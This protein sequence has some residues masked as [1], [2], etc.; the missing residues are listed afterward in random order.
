MTA[1]LETA[2]KRADFISTRVFASITYL[3]Q[4]NF[5]GLDLDFEYPGSRGSPAADKHRF[6][7]L[8][9][10]L[11]QAFDAESQSTGNPALL[12]SV[13]V[14][15]GKPRVDNGYEVGQIAQV[16]DWI[17]LMSYDLH[18][19]WE[20]TT[21]HNSPLYHRSAEST[22]QR[23]L[24]VE[25]AANYWVQKGCPASKLVI[26]MP[27][28]GRG[29]TLANPA[30]H[31]M[32]AAA[33]G[34]GAAGPITATAGFIAYYE[35]CSE[36]LLA[37]G[38]RVFHAEH[39]VPYAFKNDQWVGYDDVQSLT[40]KVNWLQTQGYGG[41]MVWAL[42]LDDFKH[43]VCGQATPFTCTSRPDGFYA[44]PADCS[45]FY[46]CVWGH[47]FSFDCPPGIYWDPSISNCNW[48][49]NI[50]LAVLSQC[51]LL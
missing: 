30:N 16:V 13:A 38:T 47:P 27:T 35:V 21:G 10:E 1:M 14:P 31:G 4:R 50:P 41:W 45:K 33:N 20:S 37:G 5:D 18:G 29:F 15:A 19:S 7:L 2:A 44:N 6:T 22:A 28:Y 12:L 51:T 32:G 48:I 17:G 24:N 25:W 49:W 26:G 40:G 23:Q 3:R 34:A 11:R 43:N 8:C 39:Q 36:F 9:Q 46:R 42:D